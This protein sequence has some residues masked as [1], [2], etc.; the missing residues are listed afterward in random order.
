MG[1]RRS[2]HLNRLSRRL[3]C[4][5]VMEAVRVP[6]LSVA[7][8]LALE[9]DDGVR[10][11]Y[12]GG[13]I[14]A[15]SGGSREHNTIA[16]NIFAALRAKLRG[17]PCQVYVSDFKL[18]LEIARQ[19]IFYY[20]DVLVTCNAAGTEKYFLRLPTLIFEVLSPSTEAIDRREKKANYQQAQSLE[21][22][23]IVAQERREVTIFR[24][25]TGWEGEIHTSADA[26]VEFRSIRQ[27]MT[28]AEIYEDVF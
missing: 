21:E 17:G 2:R 25:A 27:S 11:E 20:P 16:G 13:E 26:V 5:I 6:L 1:D 15:M 4:P 9:A 23:V 19:D 3:R 18:R 10:H 28:V 12:I 7:D 14:H 22:Y 8:Y 24:R